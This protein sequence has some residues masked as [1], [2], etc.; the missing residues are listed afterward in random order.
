MPPTRAPPLALCLSRR[1][2]PRPPTSAVAG[3]GVCGTGGRG[4]GRDCGLKVSLGRGIGSAPRGS[5][6]T[7]RGDRAE[8]GAKVWVVARVP[9]GILGRGID[10]AAWGWVQVIGEGSPSFGEAFARSAV[11]GE[12]TAARGALP[13]ECWRC[14]MQGLAC[15]SNESMS[16]VIR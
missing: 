14:F 15:G 4:S 6:W 8:P 12:A 10:L 7:P 3:R 2:P 5:T 13:K 1:L 16:C 9:L 11:R